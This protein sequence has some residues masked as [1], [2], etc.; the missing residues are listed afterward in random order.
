MI[1]LGYEVTG[2][3]FGVADRLKEIDKDYFIF[4]S[5]RH[6]RFE[7]HNRS[8][9]GRTLCLVLPFDR[10][11]ERTVRLVRR[12]R[13]ENAERLLRETEEE[14]ERKHREDMKKAVRNAEIATEK[15]FSAL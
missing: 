9:R 11:D 6:R 12:T 14:N 13:I 8:Q 5:Y 7:V 1:G 15:A 2:D 3:L 10:L 4:F